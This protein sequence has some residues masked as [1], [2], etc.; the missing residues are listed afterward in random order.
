[1]R[2]VPDVFADDGLM[3]SGIGCA[4]VDGFLD[5]DPVVDELIDKPLMDEI[6]PPGHGPLL[7]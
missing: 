5:I 6:A 4:L 1:M 2:L 3:L 7:C